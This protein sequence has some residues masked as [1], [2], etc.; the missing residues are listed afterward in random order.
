MSMEISVVVGDSCNKVKFKDGNKTMELTRNQLSMGI[1]FLDAA[2]GGDS[3]SRTSQ[4]LTE[5]KPHPAPSPIPTPPEGRSL[6]PSEEITTEL[7][8]V[9]TSTLEPDTS[10]NSTKEPP[11]AKKPAVSLKPNLKKANMF[12]KEIEKYQK[13]LDEA[14]DGKGSAGISDVAIKKAIYKNKNNIDQ[15]TMFSVFRKITGQPKEIFE[16]FYETAE[17]AI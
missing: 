3:P 14:K 12:M 5:P 4:L 8:N 6:G 11:A 2:E 10:L 15:P 9:Q 7:N 1:R 13:E 17:N 16:V